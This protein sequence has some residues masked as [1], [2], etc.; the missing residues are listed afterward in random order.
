MKKRRVYY[1][2]QIKFDHIVVIKLQYNLYKYLNNIK[3]VSVTIHYVDYDNN[4]IDD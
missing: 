4:N 3:I 2:T 1:K